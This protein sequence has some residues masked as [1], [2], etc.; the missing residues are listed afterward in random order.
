[1]QL[2]VRGYSP[3]FLV[4]YHDLYDY[5]IDGLANDNSHNSYQTRPAEEIKRCNDREDQL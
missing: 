5:S 2:A 4:V 3:L 1:M